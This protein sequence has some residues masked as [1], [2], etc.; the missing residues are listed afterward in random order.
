MLTFSDSETIPNI[1]LY[2]NQASLDLGA[3]NIRNIFQTRIF[4]LEVDGLRAVSC[5]K[6]LVVQEDLEREVQIDNTLKSVHRLE[7]GMWGWPILNHNLYK[8]NAVFY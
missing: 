5:R 2:C 4:R 6:I 3:V 8:H 7:V 1:K